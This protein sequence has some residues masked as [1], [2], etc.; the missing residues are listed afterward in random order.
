M[1]YAA[2]SEIVG[3]RSGDLLSAGVA[4]DNLVM[5]LYFLTLFALPSLAWLGRRYRKRHFEV[6][7]DSATLQAGR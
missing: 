1:N 4:A 5:A 2:V 6:A 7:E 3:L